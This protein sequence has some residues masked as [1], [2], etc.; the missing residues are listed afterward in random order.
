[1]EDDLRP[2]CLDAELWELI[3]YKEWVLFLK[4]KSEE[5]RMVFLMYED[6]KIEFV[7][8]LISNDDIGSFRNEWH[9]NLFMFI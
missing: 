3:C 8:L 9:R 1:V 2:T 7:R 5:T 4:E 6:S